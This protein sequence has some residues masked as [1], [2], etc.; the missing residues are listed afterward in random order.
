MLRLIDMSHFLKSFT[1][2]L[3]LKMHRTIKSEPNAF[4]EAKLQKCCDFETDKVG[5]FI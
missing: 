5:P 1:F 3:P 4:F 2:V